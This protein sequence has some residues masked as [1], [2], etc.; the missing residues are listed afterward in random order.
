MSLMIAVT[1]PTVPTSS[2]LNIVMLT[3][4]NLSLDVETLVQPQSCE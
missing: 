2:L 3:S 1:V 4:M